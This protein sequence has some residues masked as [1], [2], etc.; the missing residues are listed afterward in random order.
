MTR[1]RLTTKDRA[2]IFL[3]ADGVCHLCGV[4]ILPERETWEVSH[5]TPLEMG[6]ADDDTNRRPAHARCHRK[7]TSEVDIPLIAKTKRIQYRHI[8]AKAPSRNPLPCGR[9]SK[10]R[11]K[12]SGE[13]VLR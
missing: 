13:V 8:G 2:R 1:S 5:P 6:G 10:F 3:A 9:R 11:K 4:K 7:Q 12:I